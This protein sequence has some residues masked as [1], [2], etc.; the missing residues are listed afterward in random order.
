MRTKYPHMSPVEDVALDKFIHAN[1]IKGKW[2][3]D[4]HLI[5]PG[6]AVPAGAPEN[7]KRMWLMLKAKRIDALCISDTAV[8]IVE[9]KPRITVA[10]IGQLLLYRELYKELHHPDKPIELWLVGYYEDG[11]VRETA[12]RNGIH[13]WTVE[14]NLG[15]APVAK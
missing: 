8:N 6:T 13:V 10:G 1:I 2:D 5:V 4:V 9:V 12:E 14:W 11:V 7:Y 3:F 15:I